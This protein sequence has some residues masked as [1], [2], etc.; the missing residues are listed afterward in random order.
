MSEWIK[1]DGGPMPV[2]ASQLVKVKFRNH[3]LVKDDFYTDTG[4]AMNWDWYHD[5]GDD[6]IVSYMIV[7]GVRK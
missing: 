4:K 7:N 6:D 1:H 3:D 2:I 5:L